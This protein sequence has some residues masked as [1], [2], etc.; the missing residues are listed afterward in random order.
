MGSQ[1]WF[2]IESDF[3]PKNHVAMSADSFGC[4]TWRKEDAAGIEWVEARDAVN[5]LW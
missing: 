2:L 4:Y 1:Q 5:I 3:I